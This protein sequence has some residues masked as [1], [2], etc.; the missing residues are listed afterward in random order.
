MNRREFLKTT[1]S[2]TAGAMLT[3]SS[4]AQSVTAPH[5]GAHTN[6]A[7]NYTFTAPQVDHPA[8][9]EEVRK[10]VV[11]AKHAKALGSGHSF[12]N[13]ADTAGDQLGMLTLGGMALDAQGKTVTVGAGVKYGQF[14]PW[15]DQQGF[16]VHNLA[17]LPHVTVAG[18]CATGTH[19]SGIR[20]GCLSTAV[21]AFE[22]VDASGEVHT[23]S[24]AANPDIFPGAVVALGAL[25]VVTRTTLRVVPR[26]DIAQVVYENL[27]FDQLEHNFDAIMGS[28]YSVS[29]FTTWQG[30]RAN[31][32]WLK[33]L[34][35]DHT[36]LPGNYPAELYG[37]SMQVTKLHPVPGHEATACTDQFGQPGPWYER[38]P[39]FKMN[40]TPSSGNEIQ[41]EYFVPREHAYQAI[42][43]VEKLRDRITPHLFITE[44]RCIAA[45]D[46]WMSMAYQQDSLAIHFTW[47]PEPAAVNA[48]IPLIEQALKPF[49]PRPHW[50]KVNTIPASDLKAAYPRYGDFVALVKKFDPQGKFRNAYLERVL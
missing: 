49:R 50:A 36:P 39:H 5:Q 20:N 48:V 11:A 27:S 35:G 38:L 26:F 22:L 3:G 6:W 25:G 9:A 16:A 40:F 33:Q 44:L 10:L 4:V 18:A 43:A 8:S 30:H 29:L 19:G 45:D 47:K 41:T 14:A 7:G 31:Q 15:L 1:S 21:E 17:S 28:G 37:A 46:L 24:R 2:I 32:V 42:L 12:N 34:P 23:I 13:I